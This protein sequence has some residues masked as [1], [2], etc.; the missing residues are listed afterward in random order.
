MAGNHRPV[1][2]AGDLAAFSLR[3]SDGYAIQVLTIGRRFVVLSASKG[4]V[5]AIYSTRGRISGNRIRARFGSLGRIAVVYHPSHRCQGATSIGDQGTFRG[6]VRFSGERGYTRVDARRAR[7][8]T[9]R[10][11]RDACDR[12]RRARS[13]AATERLTTHLAAV[14]RRSG[15]VVSV[16]VLGSG[17]P[18]IWLQASTQEHRGR[19][20]IHRIAYAIVGGS[21]AFVS[22]EPGKHPAFVTLKPPKP[23]SGTGVFEE[24]ADLS[25]SWTGTLAV[26]L[27]GAG[28]VSLAGPRFASNFC[29]RPSGNSG[30]ALFPPVQRP[31]QI[32]QDSG[33]QSQALRDTRLSWSR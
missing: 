23:F 1:T 33:S 18:R 15:R 27:P 26:W 24:G 11:G 5:G 22:S 25:P 29:R 30:C 20:Q 17:Q 9:I 12:S 28:K 19:M 10:P 4:H 8:F 13:S 31:V 14:A 16:D 6:V 3:G 32:A 21:K 7:G 2:R